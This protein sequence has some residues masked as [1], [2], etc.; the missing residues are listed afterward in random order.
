MQTNELQPQTATQRMTTK[1]MR[2]AMR[3]LENE[4]EVTLEN[5]QR[6]F[7]AIK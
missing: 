5:I 4:D 3:I 1:F 6:L 2:D 7:V